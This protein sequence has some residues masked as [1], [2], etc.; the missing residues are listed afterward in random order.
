MNLESNCTPYEINLWHIDFNKAMKL[1]VTKLKASLWVCLW[2]QSD[3]RTQWPISARL[4]LDSFPSKD[5]L[6]LTCVYV[7]VLP[8][9]QETA[10]LTVH[11]VFSP[12]IAVFS[13]GWLTRPLISGSLDKWV[14]RSTRTV[15]HGRQN[16]ELGDCS[17]GFFFFFSFLKLPGSI[18]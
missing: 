17:R 18:V 16:E 14:S 4:S 3:E 2:A 6:L 8:L 11:K 12:G 10:P 9:P 7:C 5:T 13:P 15:T 1:N